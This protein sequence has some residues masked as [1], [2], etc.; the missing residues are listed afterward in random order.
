MEYSDPDHLLLIVDNKIE[1]LSTGTGSSAILGISLP[2]FTESMFIGLHNDRAY[3][4]VPNAPVPPLNPGAVVVVSMGTGAIAA[5]IPVAG[6]RH[7][8]QSHDGNHILALSDNT[9]TIAMI[10]PSLIGTTTNPVVGTLNTGFDH[11]VWAIFSSDDST[12]YVLNCGP[13]CGGTQ[14]SVAVVNVTQPI[15]VI[16]ATIDVRGASIGL[17]TGST[18]YVAGTPPNLPCVAGTT[19]AQ[20]CGT[21]DVVNLGTQTATAVANLITDGHH[22]RMELGAN[23]QIFI[24]AQGCTSIV[25]SGSSPEVRG[26]LSILNTNNNASFHGVIN[27]SFRR[28][29]FPAADWRCHRHAVHRRPQRGLCLPEPQFVDLRHDHRQ[30]AGP[31]DAD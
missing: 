25:Q 14:A 31:T 11:P 27:Q 2:D 22:T 5:S 18:L 12:A 21:V 20:H 6:V 29:C 28:G 26:C 9:S 16:T 8:F 4:A 1:N 7:V 23:G 19:A 3:A 10:S 15:P 17:L 24:G 30:A 13:E